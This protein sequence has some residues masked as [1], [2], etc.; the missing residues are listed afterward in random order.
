MQEDRSGLA[1]TP[2]AWSGQR[3]DGNAFHR[4]LHF[5]CIFALWFIP[6]AFRCF[7]TACARDFEWPIGDAINALGNILQPRARRK[8]YESPAQR[9]STK[10]AGVADRQSF[11]SLSFS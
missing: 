11:S 7:A 9:R 6:R 2:M 10:A 5:D 8:K 3:D 4:F 1:S